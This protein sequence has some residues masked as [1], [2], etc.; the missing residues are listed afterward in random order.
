LNTISIAL[1]IIGA[2][3]QLNLG[4]LWLSHRC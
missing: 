3:D 1:P 4:R 2:I